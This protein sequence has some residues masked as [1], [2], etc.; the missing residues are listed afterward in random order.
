MTSHPLPSNLPVPEDD[1]ACAHLLNSK[2]PSIKLPST[3]NTSENLAQLPGLT[4]LFTYPRTGAPNETIPAEW[5]A[6]PGAR[7]CSPQACSFRDSLVAFR[8][9]GVNRIFGLSTQDTA[10]QQEA[11][12]RLHLSY[13]LLSDEK[14]E[15]V[16]A[17]NMPTFAWQGSALVKRSILAIVDGTVVKVWYPVFPP[18]A[19]AKIVLEWLE[20]GKA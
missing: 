5:D 10:Y 1:G 4:I 17:M 6:I 14:L 9:H 3:A 8:S 19:S 16:Q 15:F 20:S 11:R 13:D 7:G 12:E 18:D 2:V